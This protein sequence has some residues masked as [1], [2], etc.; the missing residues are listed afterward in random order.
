MHLWACCTKG[1]LL[2]RFNISQQAKTYW[3][4]LLDEFV[5]SFLPNLHKK[6]CVL[7]H[8][9]ANCIHLSCRENDPQLIK[10]SE[11]QESLRSW[12]PWLRMSDMNKQEATGIHMREAYLPF[13]SLMVTL[14]TVKLR[15]PNWGKWPGCGVNTSKPYNSCCQEIP[16]T[17]VYGHLNLKFHNTSWVL[18]PCFQDFYCV[19]MI[20]F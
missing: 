10:S 18:K 12:G 2:S 4:E 9:V 1:S 16:S 11:N 17:C 19:T 5:V 15:I 7:C 14:I 6:D 8:L 3:T 20:T 13:P